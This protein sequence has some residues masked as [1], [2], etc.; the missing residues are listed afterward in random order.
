MWKLDSRPHRPWYLSN[1]MFA[2]AFL[3]AWPVAVGIAVARRIESKRNQVAMFWG[4]IAAW[5]LLIVVVGVGLFLASATNHYNKGIRYLA[6]NPAHPD[7]RAEQQF[8]IAIDKDH[9]FADAHMN[10]GFYYLRTGSLEVAENETKDAIEIYERTHQTKIE[11]ARWEQSLSIAYNNLG[12]IAVD[13]IAK[14]P[15]DAVSL[16]QEGLA[17]FRKSLELDPKNAQARV[18]L[19]KLQASN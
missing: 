19:E 17:D 8:K 10:L 4:S 7:P 1:A 18:N 14:D 2:L 5:I 9:D 3:F 13:K 6:E 15:S 12:A 11:G 16:L